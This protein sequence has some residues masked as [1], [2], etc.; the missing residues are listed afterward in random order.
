MTISPHHELALTLPGVEAGTLT[1]LSDATQVRAWTQRK[2]E[3]Y[4]NHISTLIAIHNSV[5]PINSLPTE[6]LQKIFADVPSVSTWCDA[7]WMLSL[8]SVCRRWR[9]VLLATPEYWARGLHTVMNPNYYECLRRFRYSAEEDEN[10]VY[11]R[12]IFLGRSS[13]CPLEITMSYSSSKNG[14]GWGVFEDHFNRVT[15]F[16]VIARDPDDLDDIVTAVTSNMKRL[17]KLRLEF[18]YTRFRIPQL[19]FDWEADDLPRLRHLEIC[20]PLF[21]SVT[22]VP[23]LHTVI[24]TGPPR[25]I[26]FLPLLL[27]ALEKCPALTTLRL[28]LTHRDG[29]SENRTLK[30]VLH[31]PNLRNLTVRGGIAAVRCLLSCLSFPGPSVTS[32]EL[33][34]TYAIGRQDRGLALPNVLPKRRSASHAHQMLDGIDRLC[35]HSRRPRPIADDPTMAAMRGYVKGAERLQI[36]P[37]FWL[38]SAGHF[39]QVLTLFSGCSVTELALDLRDVPGDMDGDF[40]TKFFAALPNLSRLEL[41]SHTTESR[42]TKRDIA[43]HYLASRREPRAA[44]ETDVIRSPPRRGVT[45]AWV[46][47]ADRHDTSKLE[48]E[49]R[50]VEQVLGGHA[51]AGGRLDWLELYVVTSEPHYY[52]Q[53]PAD[54]TQV[55]TDRR[56]SRLVAEDYVSGLEAVAEVVVVGGGWESAEEDDDDDTDLEDA[57]EEEED[58]D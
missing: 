7:L 22:T 58:S 32:V 33:N 13:P 18:D 57:A 36:T 1:E 42:A 25:D 19:L 26:N 16:E 49:L 10:V 52:G 23:S 47:R 29:P 35:F 41:L 50:T 39:L 15:I 14:P 51:E 48:E 56:V 40:Y 27:D 34:L 54:V 44:L 30:R 5:A 17:E 3:E 46:L 12:T 11:D 37:V 43:T 28:E 24:L 45:L 31:L 53:Q 6:I 55:K 9:P 21:S 4:K 8:G 2:L 20:G 38:D